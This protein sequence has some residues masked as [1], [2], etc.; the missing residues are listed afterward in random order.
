MKKVIKVEP[1]D[2]SVLIFTTKKGFINHLG[3]SVRDLTLGSDGLCI[4][5]KPEDGDG[6]H[7]FALM[8]PPE[9]DCEIVNH[10][11]LHLAHMILE[12]HG[13][14]INASMSCSELQCYMQSHITRQIREK[15]YKIK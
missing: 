7:F 1:F 8:I 14:E 6:G 12:Y 10:E 9:H 15:V 5:M 13:I 11:A 2:A 3:E 4:E